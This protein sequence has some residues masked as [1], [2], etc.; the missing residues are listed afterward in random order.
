MVPPHPS[1]ADP[2]EA[3]RSAHVLGAHAPA[4]GAFVGGGSP[5]PL[6]AQ[7]HIA[8]TTHARASARTAFMGFPPSRRFV[9]AHQR[10]SS[11][12]LPTSRFV[13]AATPPTVLRLPDR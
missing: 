12:R 1:D 5:P 10:R 8:A 13:Q 3:L 7:L 2:Q 11:P 4:S 9:V 6:G